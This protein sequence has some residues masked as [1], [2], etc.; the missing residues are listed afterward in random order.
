M[1]KLEDMT[2][3]RNGWALFTVFM[4]IML[5]IALIDFM[6]KFWDYE[7]L[8]SEYYNHRAGELCPMMQYE[9]EAGFICINMTAIQAPNGCIVNGLDTCCYNYKITKNFTTGRYIDGN[10]QCLA[11][12][13]LCGNICVVG[14]LCDDRPKHCNV[15]FYLKS[16]NFTLEEF[17]LK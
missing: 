16:Q 8:Q 10:I 12:E 1:T 13:V 17:G 4:L 15:P 7:E 5:I 14:Y 9:T 11:E 6:W 2:E 3:D